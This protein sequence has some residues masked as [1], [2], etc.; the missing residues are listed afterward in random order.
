M[1]TVPATTTAYGLSSRRTLL[2]AGVASTLALLG[3]ALGRPLTVRAADPNDVVL[4][5]TNT[6]AAVTVINNT[7][8]TGGLMGQSVGPGTGVLGVSAS[9]QGMEGRSDTGV[10]L[11]AISNSP[12]LPVIL[13]QALGGGIAVEG[14]VG[15]DIPQRSAGTGVSGRGPTNGVQGM[16]DNGFGV[17]GLANA[18]VGVSGHSE[19]FV[20]VA[21]DSFTGTGV[22]GVNGSGGT[23]VSGH[24]P[25]GTG[26]VGDGQ[27]GIGVLASSYFGTALKAQ[28][29]VEFSTATL[30]TIPAGSSSVTVSP[31]ID[32]TSDSK[33]LCTLLSNPGPGR[34]LRYVSVNA[35]ADTFTVFLSFNASAPTKVASFVIS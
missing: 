9:G 28:G 3:H 22:S 6:A 4:G 35:V 20:G 13:S 21:G 5:Q 18:G 15:T 1:D 19:S 2:A 16:T 32:L 27:Y 30:A 17:R 23:G 8:G 12:T 33:I 14:Y 26:V 25:N 24:S 29:A 11:F 7:A 31:G 34:V 10:G